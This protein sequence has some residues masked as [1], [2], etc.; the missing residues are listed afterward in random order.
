MFAEVLFIGSEYFSIPKYFMD[1]I[2]ELLENL[3]KLYLLVQ[4]SCAKQIKSFHIL[5]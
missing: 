5:S 4:I 2:S 1:D 3:K